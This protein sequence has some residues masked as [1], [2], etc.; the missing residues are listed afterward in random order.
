MP[1]GNSILY[2]IE[3][4]IPLPIGG[5]ILR[6]IRDAI[7]DAILFPIK[8]PIGSLIIGF[9]LIVA[10]VNI[11][12]LMDKV[13]CGETF[14]SGHFAFNILILQ[15]LSDF[16]F[17][18]GYRSLDALPYPLLNALLGLLPYPLLYPFLN[19]FLCLLL[20][21]SLLPFLSAFLYLPLIGS[22]LGSLILSRCLFLNSSP[23]GLEGRPKPLL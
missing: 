13:S 20:L 1:I 12:I 16:S 23:N 5:S 2:P 19:P 21:P 6:P 18:L 17:L 8:S 11:Q 15:D 4:S 10:K 9:I 14:L 3:R 7:G 22:L